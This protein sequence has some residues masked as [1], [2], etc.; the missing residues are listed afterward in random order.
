MASLH[1]N[2]FSI[3]FYPANAKMNMEVIITKVIW[4][5]M[6]NGGTCGFLAGHK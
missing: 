3:H 4:V 6:S 1:I 2:G 5:K